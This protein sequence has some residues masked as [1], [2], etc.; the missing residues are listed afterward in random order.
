MNRHDRHY[1]DQKPEK[2]KGGRGQNLRFLVVLGIGLAA[3]LL[4]SRV[5]TRPDRAVTAPGPVKL[6]RLGNRS[7]HETS[8]LNGIEGGAKV[9]QSALVQSNKAK[10]GTAENPQGGNVFVTA[11]L[12]SNPSVE[13]TVTKTDDQHPKAAIRI[14]GIRSEKAYTNREDAVQDAHRTARLRLAE[15]LQS[16][17]PPIQVLPSDEQIASDYIAAN[18]AKDVQASQEIKDAWKAGHL[19][20]NRQ[21][22]TVDL[23][24]SESQLRT[25]RGKQRLIELGWIL[26]GIA[27]VLGL[28]YGALRADAAVKNYFT[29]SAAP[30][31]LAS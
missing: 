27:G 5:D 14:V 22:V 12:V 25:L 2:P 4:I 17:D 15:V 23:E 24:V 7:L 19:D 30:A 11:P 20:P 28:G 31:A 18:S 8:E 10:F 16:L 1:R 26:G 6:A 9:G 29:K 3:V 21:W 13:V